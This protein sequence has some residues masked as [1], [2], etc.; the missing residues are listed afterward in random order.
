MLRDFFLGFVKIH[1]LHHAEQ[2]PVYGS[3]LI[4]ELAHHGYEI[5]PGTLY[6]TLHS[7]EKNGYLVK[8]DRVVDGKVRKY[9]SITDKGREALAEARL[10]I[11]EL[12]SEV[13]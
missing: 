4:Q 10:K 12:V 3:Y 11:K 2:E 5:S 1:I 6:P 8:E 13:L 9:Y 7:L